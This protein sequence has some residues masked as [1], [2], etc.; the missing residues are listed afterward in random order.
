MQ[1]LGPNMEGNQLHEPY[2]H[3]VQIS[4]N[5]EQISQEQCD[6]GFLRLQTRGLILV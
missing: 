6:L 4:Q 1:V 3:G 2:A 5:Q